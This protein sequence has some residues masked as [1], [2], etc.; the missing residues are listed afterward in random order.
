MEPT[1][2]LLVQTSQPKRS[3]IPVSSGSPS[4]KMPTSLSK[5]VTRANDKEKLHNEMRCLKTPSKF[6]KSLTFGALTLW[7]RSRLRE[8]TS[9]FSWQSTTCRNGL[10]RKRSPPMRPEKYR[11]LTRLSPLITHNNVGKWR[12]R[13]AYKNTIGYT[14]Y[15]L[16]YGKACHLS[17]EL[18]HK[19][20][21]AL[22]QANFNPVIM[23]D[24]RKVQLNELNELRDHAYES[25]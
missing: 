23:G 16:V 2:G 4:I 19:A 20:Y 7:A 15:K 25:A 21:W 13:T 17:I 5:T 14:P 8:G 12:L 11:A 3:L 22:K 6:V 1:G 10:K 24:H 9:I 18:E